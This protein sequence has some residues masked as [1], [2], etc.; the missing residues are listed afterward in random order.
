MPPK[1]KAE[2]IPDDVRAFLDYVDEHV[3]IVEGQSHF[4]CTKRPG[5]A[6][7]KRYECLVNSDQIRLPPNSETATEAFEA[8]GPVH[9]FRCRHPIRLLDLRPSSY[10]PLRSGIYDGCLMPPDE[11]SV[12]GWCSGYLAINGLLPEPYYRLRDRFAD[13]SGLASWLYDRRDYLRHHFSGFVTTGYTGSSYYSLFELF[14]VSALEP[15]G[16]DAG[17]YWA[18][19]EY[20]SENFDEITEA[21]IGGDMLGD[22]K[23]VNRPDAAPLSLSLKEAVLRRARELMD[24]E[25]DDC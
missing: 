21:L 9:E 16:V 4:Y 25:D 5:D 11:A 23:T 6:F 10:H 3:L 17:D 15:L 2:P 8:H 7:G 18:L 13:G 19:L 20:R 14:D 12:V 24:Q 1:R 22:W